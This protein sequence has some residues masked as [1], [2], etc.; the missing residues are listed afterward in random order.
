MAGVWQS[1]GDDPPMVRSGGSKEEDKRRRARISD[2]WL[3]PRGRR[4]FRENCMGCHD[5]IYEEFI[6]E[7]S[8]GGGGIIP[9]FYSKSISKVLQN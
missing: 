1:P 3:T 6:Y 2:A 8:S 9:V 4:I 5:G 7:Y